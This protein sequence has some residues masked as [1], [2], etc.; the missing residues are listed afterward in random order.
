MTPS[1]T[2]SC[3]TAAPTSRWAGTTR[4]YKASTA[5]YYYNGT[6]GT[7]HEVL[8]VGWDDNYAAS[9]FATAPAGNGAFIVKNSWG[10]SWG[11]GGYFYASYYDT[12]F[13]RAS[14]PTAVFD[15]AEATG[16]YTGV[17]QYDPLGDCNDLGYGSTTGWFANVF[18]A[19]ANAPCAPSAST[20]WPRARRTRST[21]GPAWR[22]RR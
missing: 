2:P 3:S 13:G 18:T 1:R 15:D 7:N 21:R 17:Y 22:P 19:Q 14:N 5:S 4:R 6:S 10:T 20:R 16:N 8:I 9:N 12:R 11:S